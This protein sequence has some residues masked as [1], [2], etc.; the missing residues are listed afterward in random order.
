[1]AADDVTGTLPPFPDDVPT[2]PLLVIDYEKLKAGDQTEQNT[3]WNACTTLGFFYLKNH[4]VD[5]QPMW[6]LG[7]VTMAMPFE[8][9][10]KYTQGE[11]GRSFGYKAAG[12][13]IIDEYGNVDTIELFN[14]AKDDALARP[15]IVHRVYAPPVEEG[16]SVIR[17]FVEASEIIQR[18]LMDVM[19]DR[20]GL[21]KEVLREKHNPSEYSGSEA[22]ILRNP[23]TTMSKEQVALG[24]HTDFGS[25]SFLHNILGG[26]QVLLPETKKWQF[27]K[28]LPGH[29]ICNIGDTLNIYSGGILVLFQPL[30]PSSCYSSTWRSI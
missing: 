27:V 4:G 3:L 6:E 8:E 14:V 29:A 21:P 13:D 23:P 26:L 7:E 5:T 2:Q 17:A 28:P 16:M 12:T 1:M 10:V 15:N 20:L 11:S 24:E 25:L 19:S 30:K 22:R 18:Y 9:K